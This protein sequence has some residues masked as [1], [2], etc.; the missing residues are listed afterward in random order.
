[1]IRKFKLILV[2]LMFLSY[3][4]FSTHN[5][6]G[7]I[8]YEVIANFGVW[9]LAGCAPGDSLYALNF[10]GL[11]QCYS[12]ALPYSGYHFLRD[13][14]VTILLVKAIELLSKLPVL[15]TGKS[16]AR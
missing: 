13:I 14:P 11:V 9:V 15:K 1:M 16:E 5:R 2:A 12:A 6:A 8:I 7:E 4:G 3:Q 10:Q